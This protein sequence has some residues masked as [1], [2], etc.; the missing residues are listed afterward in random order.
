MNRL[1]PLIA[2]LLVT[3]TLPSATALWVHWPDTPNTPG[4]DT[5]VHNCRIHV[6]VGTLEEI[7]GECR[8]PCVT[9]TSGPN[10]PNAHQCVRVF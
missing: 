7:A 9:V 3:M 5:D 6:W 8:T 1:T 10:G 4:P 2:L